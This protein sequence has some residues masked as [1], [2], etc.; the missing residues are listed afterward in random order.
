LISVSASGKLS[1]NVAND[2]ATL[3]QQRFNDADKAIL[4]YS[5]H[6]FAR[7]SQEHVRAS[8]RQPEPV[9]PALASTRSRCHIR[10]PMAPLT[11]LIFRFGIHQ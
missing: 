6:D 1:K 9:R 7:P 4:R 2:H 10:R 11:V 3:K 8:L 5:S